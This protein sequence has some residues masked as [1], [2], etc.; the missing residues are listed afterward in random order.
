M[1]L[2]PPRIVFTV[3]VIATTGLGLAGTAQASPLASGAGTSAGL[4]EVSSDP[5]TDTDAQ[6]A[7]EVEPDTYSW[8]KTVVSGFQVGRIVD[9]GASDIGWATS[10]DG[11][12]T[13]KH[14]YLPGLTVNEGGGQYNA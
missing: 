6:H 7:T 9:G 12:T 14:G 3:A 2:S 11:G 8:G 5:F 4:T 1:R 10:V 13:W